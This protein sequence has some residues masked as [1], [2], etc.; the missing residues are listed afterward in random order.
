MSWKQGRRMKPYRRCLCAD[1]RETNN[2][3]VVNA[4]ASE[5]RAADETGATLRVLRLY[6]LAGTLLVL[7]VMI[8]M[9]GWGCSAFGGQVERPLH[10]M[11]IV[12]S[13]GNPGAIGDGGRAYG[14]LQ[15]HKEVI[16]DVNRR[17]GTGYT[18][19]DALHP[20]TAHLIA[21]QYLSMHKAMGNPERMARVWNGGPAG[22][23]KRATL[24]YWRRVS[25]VMERLPAHTPSAGR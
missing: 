14:V 13:G 12:E 11:T 19:R 4:A 10:A 8:L 22:S 6:R 7:V 23:R 15:I 17:H 16:T 5:K 2:C 24:P 9:L 25:R 18:L 20:P 21:T 1:C 3:K